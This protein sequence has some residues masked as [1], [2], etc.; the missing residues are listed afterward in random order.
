MHENPQRKCKRISD[1]RLWKFKSAANEE[2][3]ASAIESG[4]SLPS[5]SFF[6]REKQKC[7]GAISWCARQRG[8]NSPEIACRKRRRVKCRTTRRDWNDGVVL[9]SRQL[10]LVVSR[11]TASAVATT[12]K[13]TRLNRVAMRANNTFRS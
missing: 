2:G 8:F 13:E 6:A 9:V 12:S 3:V 10:T 11:T 7:R 4:G 5:P 1:S